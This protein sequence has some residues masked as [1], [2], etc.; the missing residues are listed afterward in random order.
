ML[1]NLHNTNQELKAKT[2]SLIPT[3]AKTFGDLINNYNL[4]VY[5]KLSGSMYPN[6]ALKQFALRGDKRNVMIAI[7]KRRMTGIMEC[8]VL[9]R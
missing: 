5:D 4:N 7:R 2:S 9:L 3:H 8:T 1:W 6:G